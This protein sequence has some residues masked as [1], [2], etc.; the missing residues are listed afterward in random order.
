[1]SAVSAKENPDATP[2]AQS[3]SC[4]MSGKLHCRFML[5]NTAYHVA[6]EERHFSNFAPL[7]L[8]HETKKMDCKLVSSMPTENLG[9]ASLRVLMVSNR[10]LRRLE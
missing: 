4:L 6:K 10:Q 9:G 8:L 7:V 1:M 3:V 2:L 5:F